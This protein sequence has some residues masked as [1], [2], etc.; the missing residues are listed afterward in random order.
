MEGLRAAMTM[1]PARQTAVPKRDVK[2]SLVNLS[3]HRTTVGMGDVANGLLKG[4]GLDP[5][6][7]T[8]PLHKIEEVPFSVVVVG[9]HKLPHCPPIENVR[10]PEEF[11]SG[12]SRGVSEGLKEPFGH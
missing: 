11:L 8:P 10:L 7:T 9:L 12:F 3:A 2:M 4:V 5:E 6:P 1:T